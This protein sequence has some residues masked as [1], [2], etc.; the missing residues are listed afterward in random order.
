[1]NGSRAREENK[2]ESQSWSFASFKEEVIHST[3][4]KNND[5]GLEGANVKMPTGSSLTKADLKRAR[6][7]NGLQ[8]IRLDAAELPEYCQVAT[9]TKS[10]VSSKI[11][12]KKKINQYMIG[13]VLAKGSFGVVKLC[14]SEDDGQQYAVKIMDKKML[15]RKFIGFRKN[16]Y[17]LVKKELAVLCQIDHPN[18]V[19]LIE[20][21]DDDACNKIYLVMEF[22][23]GGDLKQM[24]EKGR[25]D[26]HQV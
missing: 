8:A 5:E 25:F 19:R 20:T 24:Q 9:V 4:I 23:V 7:E 2:R 1:M 26:E 10:V 13:N 18:C 11:G 6:L 3:S 15:K 12:G 17:D 14:Q 21:I 16:A 22:I